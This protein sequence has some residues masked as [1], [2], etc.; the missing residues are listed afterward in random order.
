MERTPSD[1]ESPRSTPKDRHHGG[2][3]PPDE[4]QD[5]PEQNAGYDRAVRRGPALDPHS[6][7][8]VDDVTDSS[9]E[10]VDREF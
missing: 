5:R 2:Q 6:D 1:R 10:T 4:L 3:E 8:E 9:P 7:M